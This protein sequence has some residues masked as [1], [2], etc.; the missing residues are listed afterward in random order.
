[1]QLLSLFLTQMVVIDE[2]GIDFDLLVDVKEKR[3]ARLTEYYNCRKSGCNIPRGS[4]WT[5][6]GN[7]DILPY[8]LLKKPKSTD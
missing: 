6:A 5:Y 3:R 8:Y 4:V 7:Y 2:N 1:M